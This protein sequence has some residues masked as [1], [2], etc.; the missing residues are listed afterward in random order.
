[1]KERLDI[2]TLELVRQRAVEFA[3]RE[4][5]TGSVLRSDAITDFLSGD[6]D[7]LLTLAHQQEEQRKAEFQLTLEQVRHCYSIMQTHCIGC[8]SSVSEHNVCT[9]CHK[10][11]LKAE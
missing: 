11:R 3:K 9:L 2:K 5:K 7:D 6:L 8:F 4:W 1:M 10:P